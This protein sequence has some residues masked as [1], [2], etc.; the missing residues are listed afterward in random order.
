MSERS[1]VRANVRAGRSV[2][3]GTLARVLYVYTRAAGEFLAALRAFISADRCG[4]ATNHRR[5]R[6]R[7]LAIVENMSVTCF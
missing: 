5:R 6:R 7:C 3:N 4:V 2:L 1:F